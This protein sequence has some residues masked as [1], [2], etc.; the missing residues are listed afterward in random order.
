MNTI[1]KP[2]VDAQQDC[3]QNTV[4]IK[5]IMLSRLKV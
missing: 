1:R 4:S 3:L 5:M 2:S